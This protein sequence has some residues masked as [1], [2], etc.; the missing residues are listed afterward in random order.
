MGPGS[1]GPRA[2]LG[3]GPVWA[4]GTFGP[5]ARLG[6]EPIWG[7]GPG[8][9]LGVHFRTCFKKNNVRGPGGRFFRVLFFLRVSLETEGPGP[10]GGPG[11]GPGPGPMGPEALYK[12]M[13]PGYSGPIIPLCG[14]APF[15]LPMSARG[16]LASALVLTPVRA[17]HGGRRMILRISYDLYGPLEV[18][19]SYGDRTAIVRWAHHSKNTACDLYNFYKISVRPP[20]NFAAPCQSRRLR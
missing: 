16:S 9:F 5:R 11:P 20:Y 15:W 13:G 17:P 6:P 2:P 7:P 1:I 3:P 12:P 14:P 18:E 4:Q 8:Q 10:Q 19:K